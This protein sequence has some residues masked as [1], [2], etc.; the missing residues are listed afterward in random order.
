MVTVIQLFIYA[1]NCYDRTGLPHLDAIQ[2]RGISLGISYGIFK[3]YG[4]S[5]SIKKYH[6]FFLAAAQKLINFK[7]GKHMVS[8]NF[9]AKTRLRAFIILANF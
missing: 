7:Q 8:F 3:L 4:I 6:A 2:R 5:R 9:I 1:E